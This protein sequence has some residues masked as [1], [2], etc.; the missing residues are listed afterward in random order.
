M[1]RMIGKRS[2]GRAK[3]KTRE[4]AEAIPTRLKLILTAEKLFAAHGIGAVSLREIGIAAGQRNNSSVAYHFKSKLELVRAISAYRIVEME[5]PRRKLLAEIERRGLQNDARAL[6]EVLSI[7]LVNI[8]DDTGRHSYAGFSSHYLLSY[9]PSKAGENLRL[10]PA[11][12]RV[13]ELIQRA[14]DY[15]PPAILRIRV[16]L[17]IAMFQDVL[18]RLDDE[19]AGKFPFKA[20]LNDRLD[21]MAG[22]LCAP[23]RAGRGRGLF[24]TVLQS[25]EYR[26]LKGDSRA[27]VTKPAS[28]QFRFQKQA[29]GRT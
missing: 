17:C 1:P 19:D 4:P 23:Y 2:R 5:E 3:P 16:R 18:A 11:L 25:V 28:I 20:L 26:A 6:L 24:H 12:V 10:S 9:P 29:K 22:A 7:P 27:A 15:V 14:V 21:I 8:V 13:N